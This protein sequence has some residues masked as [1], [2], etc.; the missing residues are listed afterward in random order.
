[1]LIYFN[2]F[3]IYVWWIQ[4]IFALRVGSIQNARIKVHK[5]EV[6]QQLVSWDEHSIIVRGERIMIYSGEV[7]PFRIP[8]PGLW[9]DV[10][11]KIK[12][13]GFTGVSF[14]TY[15]GLLEGNPGQV[16]TDGVFSLDEFFDA[17]T[18]AGIYLIARPGPYINAE[19]AAGGIPGW[20]LRIK[21]VI[22]STD[23][24]YLDSIQNYASTVGEIIAKAQ[25]TNGGP[26]I[27]VQP[28]NEYASWPGVTNFPSQMNKDYMAFVE[29]QLLDA[30]VVVPFIVNDNLNIGN[31]APG[32]GL[33]E[34][35][36]YGIDAYP[37]RYDCGDPY[38]WPTYRFPKTWD[39]SHANYSPSTP[40]TIAEFQG[41]GGDGWGGVGEDRC[42]ILT[43]NG[44]TKVQ[45]KN[46]YS[47]GVAI[48]NVYM[49]HGGTNWGNLGYHGGYTSYDYGASITED[50][51]VWREKYSEMKLEANFLKASPAYLT[52]TTGHGE[53]GTFGVPAEIAVTPLFGA[54]NKGTNDT[55]TNFYVVRHAD[56]TSFA[57]TLYN[58]TITTSHGN[59]TIPQFGGSLV[60][61]GRDSKI[62][63]TD[64][65]VGGINMIYSSA[66]VFSWAKN[67]NDGRVLILY[68]GDGDNG[69]AAFPVSLG[70]PDVIEGHG[71]DIR[72]LGGAWVLQWTVNQ[73]R[74]VVQIGKLRIYLLWRNEAYNYWSLELEAPAPI[75]NHTSPSKS[76]IIV[77]GGYLLRTASIEGKQLKL[78][79]DINA[80]TNFEVIS[81]P[82]EVTSLLFNG[83]ILHSEKSKKGNLQ[84]HISYSPPSISLPDFTTQ[85]WHYIDS[86]P[87]L[88]PHYND[89]LWTPLDH[90]TTNNTLNLTTPTSMY[91]SDYG[92]HTGSLIYRGH[93]L[94]T[95]NET[96]FFI[97]TTG[98]AGFAHSAW[99][100]STF[101]GSWVGSG[102][103]QTYAQTFSLPSLKSESPY[104]FTVLID[105]MG[106]DEEAP[107]TD[108]I[109]FPRGFLDYSL[110]SHPQTDV[111]WK[112][113]G[114]IGGE[115]FI[116]KTR[117]PR[118]E[119]AMF[120][121]RQ[122]Y[123]L[124]NSPSE[125]WE[126]RNPV[127]DGVGNAGVGFFTTKFN[128]SIPEG[129][130]VPLG[131]VFNGTGTPGN[132][133]AQL[134][135]NGWQFGKYVNNLGP[136]IRFPIHEG[137]LNHQGTN[138]VALT[139][140][141]LNSEGAKIG[142]FEL[143]PNATIWSGYRKPNLVEGSGWS[144][145]ERY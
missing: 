131:F 88:Q 110:S 137:I 18:Q 15:W 129:W 28:E 75:G 60:M 80:T 142:G 11:Q 132:Y 59:I 53:N 83:K 62:H 82:T 79:G 91:A 111:V 68:G 119:G 47:F 52:A 41:G 105:H 72:K 143:V 56:F 97:N 99:L 43:N 112:M 130:D 134:F 31:F 50:R 6:L 123:H 136:Q 2:L 87:E 48:F 133:R 92:Y 93:F 145:R 14:Y 5:R 23:Q 76:S 139:L 65:D 9:L 1:M 19:T 98:G 24:D 113:T 78:T 25:I 34:V 106:Q 73:E 8:S 27:M 102:G 100:N 40:F 107:G 77:N 118:N 90:I 61:N 7:H 138:T 114:N 49:I 10:F 135:V 51:Q 69:E 55:R 94:S 81:T 30:G 36:L 4:G 140:W 35:D 124:P 85:Q 86:L 29:Q 17:A 39:I 104:V 70:V 67:H 127:S 57:R 120:A 22:R 71:V 44:A 42:A 3:L 117:G 116:D 12:A 121:E 141:S 38:I 108:A 37:M 16:I 64:Y 101:L 103:N 96:T 21:G 109:K 63:V 125:A 32:S 128:L 84:A 54:I 33:G 122:G 95:G 45:F 66:E 74:R 26:V 126:V 46:T 144:R 13:M 89:S 58:F 115:Q 20:V